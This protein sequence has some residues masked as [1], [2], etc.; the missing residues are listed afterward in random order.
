MAIVSS[1]DDAIVS[2]D[3]NSIVTSWNRAAEKMFGYTSEEMIGKSI[4]RIIPPALQ[5]EE[6]RILD[7]IARG[8]R[9]EHF[10]TGVVVDESKGGAATAQ[11]SYN[12]IAGNNLQLS[13][14]PV[15]ELSQCGNSIRPLA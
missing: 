12:L 3:L 10:E 2:K 15:G 5:S 1:S 6:T 4:M 7:T 14:I 8:E 9:I 13:T 11:A